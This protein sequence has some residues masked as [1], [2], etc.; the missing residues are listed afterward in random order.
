MIKPNPMEK[1]PNKSD[2]KTPRKLKEKK[3][4]LGLKCKKKKTEKEKGK[5]RKNLY[6]T[7][8][9]VVRHSETTKRK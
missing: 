5:I 8:L 2:H 1:F 7:T 4:A 6:V 9:L 3:T